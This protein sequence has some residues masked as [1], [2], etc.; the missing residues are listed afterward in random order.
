MKKEG[1][2]RF[3]IKTRSLNRKKTICDSFIN[4]EYLRG[5]TKS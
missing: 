4:E 1:K 3:I 2:V 5:H